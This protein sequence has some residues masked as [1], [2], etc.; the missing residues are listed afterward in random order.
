MKEFLVLFGVG[1]TSESGNEGHGRFYNQC[2]IKENCGGKW[3]D[4]QGP[5]RQCLGA[6]P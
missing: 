2:Y 1:F 5:G 3:V 6:E 4:L